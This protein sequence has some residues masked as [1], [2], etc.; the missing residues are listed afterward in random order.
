M[1]IISD[2]FFPWICMNV[3]TYNP[4]SNSMQVYA[5][6]VRRLYSYLFLSRVSLIDLFLVNYCTYWLTS[7]MLSNKFTRHT[8]VNRW[9]ILLV[10]CRRITDYLFVCT[11]I[12]ISLNERS[13]NLMRWWNKLWIIKQ[14]H[15]PLCFKNNS[16]PILL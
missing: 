15:K 5:R 14:Q 6:N 11:F 8:Y 12:W 4:K 7:Y 10:G 13:I 9:C 2:R 16:S 1:P 3:Q